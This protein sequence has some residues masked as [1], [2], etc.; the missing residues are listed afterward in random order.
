MVDQ[1]TTQIL[2]VV[3]GVAIPALGYCPLRRRCST[4]SAGPCTFCV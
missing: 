1:M 3:C 4:F 2:A